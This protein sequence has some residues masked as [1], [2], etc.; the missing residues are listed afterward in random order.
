MPDLKEV[1]STEH[2]K[3]LKT[4]ES[5]ENILTKFEFVKILN[6][7]PESR[8]IIVHAAKKQLDEKNETNRNAVVIL[9]KPHFG[10]EETKSYFELDNPLEINID[11]D[12]YKKLSVYPNKPYNSKLLL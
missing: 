7:N 8:L 3:R 1:I 9:E 12:V 11:N 10:L 2:S 5:F 6:E 4:M